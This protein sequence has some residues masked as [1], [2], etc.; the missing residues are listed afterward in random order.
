MLLARERKGKDVMKGK[1]LRIHKGKGGDPTMTR[2]PEEHY[3]GPESYEPHAY[4]PG[5][6]FKAEG[7]FLDS[8]MYVC[9]DG[10]IV[11]PPP[12]P[13]GPGGE[14]GAYTHF[15]IACQADFTWES[16]YECTP[17]L[18][19]SPPPLPHATAA[20][21]GPVSFP[22]TVEYRLEE[23]YTL[24]GQADG[25][26]K[27]T[28][29][30]LPTGQFFPSPPPAALPVSC[31]APPEI[32]HTSRPASEVAYPD[33]MT[34]I[35][36]TGYTVQDTNSL[37]I[38]CMSSGQFSPRRID[39]SLINKVNCG[40]APLF[41]DRDLI[42]VMDYNENN[43]YEYGDQLLFWAADDSLPVYHCSP[44]GEWKFVY[45]LR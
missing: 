12:F 19:G 7:G 28:R 27:F 42:H 8:V 20:H 35:V 16:P 45:S 43:Y 26:K 40:K 37:Q 9:E 3:Y 2:L 22:N 36:D 6:E 21:N 15:E 14:V 11:S 10:Y 44:E 17:M 39:V 13:P 33:S 23:G 31:G 38:R 5:S 4:E 18:C 32:A 29:S 41:T 25:G 1:L 30:C 24:N 34:Y